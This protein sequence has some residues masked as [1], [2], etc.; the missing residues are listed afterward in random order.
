MARAKPIKHLVPSP[1]PRGLLLAAIALAVNDAA[2]YVDPGE[3]PD[4]ETARVFFSGE[5]YRHYLELL[6]LPVEWLPAR[7]E[8]EEIL[9]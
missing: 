8:E 3:E 9:A 5:T 6:E 2:G 1:G 4:I 7:V